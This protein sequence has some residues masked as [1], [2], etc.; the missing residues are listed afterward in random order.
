MK[1]FLARFHNGKAFVITIG[2]LE[3]RIGYGKDSEDYFIL[4]SSIAWKAN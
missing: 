2:R 3:L 1:F 4:N